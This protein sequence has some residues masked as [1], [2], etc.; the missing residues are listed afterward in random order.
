M[1]PSTRRLVALCRKETLQIL[2]DPSTILI[3]AVFPIVLMFLFGYGVNL[4][5]GATRIGLS[6]QDDGA[7]AR[8]LADAISGSP[9][10]DVVATGP[11]EG[12]GQALAD[13]DIR[14]FV[15][16]P[17]A[18]SSEAAAGR[19]PQVQ[20]VTDGSVPNTAGFVANYVAGAIE[21]WSAFEASD[22]GARS[23]S[24]IQVEQR[25]WFNPSAISRQSLLPG[26]I[27]IVMTTIGA[28]L[29]SLVVA[30][31]WERGTMEGLLSTPVTRAE[32]ILS[33]F[34][35][36]FVLGLGS[37]A[38]CVGL[39]VGVMGVPFR[40]NLFLL[41][42][43]TA[44]FLGS[45]LG[46]GL[47]L[48]TL[49]KNQF[50]AAQAALNVGFLPAVMLSGFVYEI[51]SMPGAVQAVTLLFPARYF[52]TTLQTLFLTD[53]AGCLLLLNILVLALIATIFIG[54]VVMRTQRRLD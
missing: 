32:L 54:A 22:R 1:R 51:A 50:N 37:M 11:V 40:G 44:A 3:A 34:L 33:K 39:A 41:V 23:G 38:L 52:V 18:F 45:A 5:T 27:V 15:V 48:S 10:L 24:A 13:E 7:A 12:L 16:I 46:L 21:R 43:A 49:M 20:I 31:E 28:L 8:R 9:Y 4:D 47:L 36:Y 6:L 17:Q 14:G 26:S 42:L 25:L 35:P 30:R 29:T 2:R 53:F 19:S